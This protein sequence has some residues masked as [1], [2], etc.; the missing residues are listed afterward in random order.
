MSVER[1]VT[2]FEKNLYLT[3]LRAYSKLKFN[4]VVERN[5]TI[6]LKPPYIILSNHVT[7]LDPF[8]VNC[9]VEEPI[10]FVASASAFRKPIMKKIL[11]YAGAI[12]KTKSRTDTST[13]RNIIKAKKAGKV[14]GLFP[15]GN[16]TW[17]GLTEPM[18]FA[19]V[20]LIKSLNIPVVVVNIKGGYLS[21]P[22]WSTSV[23]KGKVEVEFKK[24]WDVGELKTLP[25][26]EIFEKLNAEITVNDF[27]WR[28]QKGIEFK[29]K[30]LAEYL[31]RYLYMCPNC[32]EIA[33]LHSEGDELTCTSCNHKVR[34]NTKGTFEQVNG[35]LH[36]EYIYDWNDWQLAKLKEMIVDEQS[37]AK[38]TSSIFEDVK[39]ARVMKEG[40]FEKLGD[41]Q[42]H[43]TATDII[44]TGVNGDAS[45]KFQF[46]IVD[47]ES[48][49]VFKS[50]VLNFFHEDLHYHVMIKDK[51]RSAVLWMCYLIAMQQVVDP[52]RENIIF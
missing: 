39:L 44:F 8:F 20:K 2:E 47:I 9:F 26:E 45:K 11:N 22:R 34:Y 38:F 50:N 37:L 1:R 6:G 12:P 40:N 24:V 43:S 52:E 21:Q 25:N 17:N 27:E 32:E 3:P 4:I 49:N 42:F 28:E 41:F 15:E 10:S 46:P 31:E 13:I 19:T 36:F 16:R 5:D 23:R 35:D 33:T 30:N 7:D 48:I 18:V 51:R 14:I 29:G